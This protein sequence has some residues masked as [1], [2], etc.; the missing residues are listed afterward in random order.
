MNSRRNRGHW[1]RV[2]PDRHQWCQCQHHR[3]RLA[4]CHPHLRPRSQPHT[5]L[6]MDTY[7]N[8]VGRDAQWILDEKDASIGVQIWIQ[9]SWG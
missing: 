6:Y 5:L 7:F 1:K 8:N 2:R 9:C 4:V 3:S